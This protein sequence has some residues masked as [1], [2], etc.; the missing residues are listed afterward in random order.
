MALGL[1]VRW[2][3]GHRQRAPLLEIEEDKT[4]PT[5][6]VVPQWNQRH[7]EPL[8]G[9]WLDPTEPLLNEPESRFAWVP[10][11][12]KPLR[13]EQKSLPVLAGGI[14]TDNRR[15][16]LNRTAPIIWT[17][18]TLLDP[19]PQS[20]SLSQKPYDT[21]VSS[22]PPYHQAKHSGVAGRVEGVGFRSLCAFPWRMG[23]LG[24]PIGVH[25][26]AG[27]CPQM[28]PPPAFG[29]DI[30]CLPPVSFH[31]RFSLSFSSFR[32]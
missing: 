14:R 7:A 21:T 2:K 12:F 20:T 29:Y 5:P 3:R 16:H 13:A 22:Y 30:L 23:G 8:S 11:G 17:W 26:D 9:L 1:P 4:A 25:G 19:S 32:L 27:L 10:S 6:S 28:E 31:L 24:G 15:P 18:R